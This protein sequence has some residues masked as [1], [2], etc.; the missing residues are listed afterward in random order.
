[1]AAGLNLPIPAGIASR[2][3][4]DALFGSSEAAL[5][6]PSPPSSPPESL[7]LA[8]SLRCSSSF[9]LPTP[10]CSPPPSR[11]PRAAGS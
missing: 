6:P 10:L 8:A 9:I 2:P 7:R 11:N 3:G 1:M 4:A 5:L